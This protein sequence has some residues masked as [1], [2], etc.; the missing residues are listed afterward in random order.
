MVPGANGDASGYLVQGTARKAI[1]NGFH[2]LV[3]NPLAP[4]DSAK[5][6]DLEVIDYTKHFPLT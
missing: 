1:E 6:E 4:P 5:E 2:I 3:A